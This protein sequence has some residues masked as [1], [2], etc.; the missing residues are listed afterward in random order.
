MKTSAILAGAMA[1]SLGLIY[2]VSPVMA[3]GGGHHGGGHHGGGHHGG[4]H[5]H[6]GGPHHG[7]GH[8]H[9]GGYYNGGGHHHHHHDDGDFWAGAAIGGLLGHAISNQGDPCASAEYRMN[10]PG[11]C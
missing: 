3:H 10:Y 5:H 4:G 1:L 7:G 11:M 9:G 8:N 2:D 6:G